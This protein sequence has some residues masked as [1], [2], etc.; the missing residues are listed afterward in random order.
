MET[1]KE[2]ISMIDALFIIGGWLFVA[3]FIGSKKTQYYDPVDP[4]DHEFHLK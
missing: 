2:G 3:Y 4:D 1:I